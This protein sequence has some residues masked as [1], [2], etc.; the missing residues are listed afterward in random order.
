MLS[1]K[2]R[3]YHAAPWA[4]ALGPGWRPLIAGCPCARV[5]RKSRRGFAWTPWRT[6]SWRW[7]AAGKTVAEINSLLLAAALGAPG[8]PFTPPAAGSPYPTDIRG[9]A[10]PVVTL[11]RAPVREAGESLPA[12]ATGPHR[13]LPPIGAGQRVSP[14][15]PLV[16]PPGLLGFIAKQ[17]TT[18]IKESHRCPTAI[19]RLHK[20]MVIDGGNMNGTEPTLCLRGASMLSTP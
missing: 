19:A 7:P 6:A 2:T 14:T 15:E 5:L 11:L 12:R 8:S 9:A 3:V 20:C 17:P 16:S 4:R 10:H 13:R 18:G 1:V